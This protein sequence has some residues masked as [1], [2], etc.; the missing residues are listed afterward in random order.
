VA[1]DLGPAIV[2]AGGA[3]GGAAVG[4]IVG[5]F[6]TKRAL[7]NELTAARET[8]GQERIGD[9]YVDLLLWANWGVQ[10]AGSI[11]G[12]VPSPVS[13]A[14]SQADR[15]FLLARVMAYGSP[16]VQKQLR[17]LMNEH[18]RDLGSAMKE[19]EAARGTPESDPAP[20]VARFDEVRKRLVAAILE[21]RAQIHWELTGDDPP[22]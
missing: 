22:R 1:T 15:D 21:L 12:S 17:S 8:R 4:G 16:T 20:Q 9:T 7:K 6:T 11:D 18:F 3:V 2:A 10:Y 13:H 14:P 5:F 19:L